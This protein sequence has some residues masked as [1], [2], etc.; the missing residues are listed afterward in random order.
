MH[1][2]FHQL[3]D[4]FE[5]N[6]CSNRV[7]EK[8]DLSSFSSLSEAELV[9][10]EISNLSN[11]GAIGPKYGKGGHRDTI[12]RIEILNPEILYQSLGRVPLED[13]VRSVMTNIRNTAQGWEANIIDHIEKLWSSR[14]KWQRLSPLDIDI[15][16]KIQRAAQAIKSDN[17]TYS[18][19][20]TFSARV[21]DDSKFMEKRENAVLAY[22]NYSSNDPIF[23]FH[24]F[25]SQRGADKITP[26]ILI[27][28]PFTHN[29]HSIGNMVDYCGIAVHELNSVTFPKTVKYV[30]T[31]E[32]L[33]SFHRH[34]CEINKA[35]DGIILYTNGQPSHA[36]KRFY[37][38]LTHL[39]PD[40]IPFYHWSDIDA[41]GL[42]ISNVLLGLN[43]KLLPHLMSA[44]ILDEYGTIGDREV[45]IGK[46]FK[47]TWLNPI[48][49][50]LSS[51]G[52][53]TVEQE[54]L[55]PLMPST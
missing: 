28:G 2:V 45:S 13:D 55:N 54:V 10:K 33:T 22:F 26:P 49:V 47:G 11:L 21:T 53:K 46:T 4:R 50:A 6:K 20:R 18:D 19:A 31:I 39:L 23:S 14:R 52:G 25:M 36:F 40:H 7:S 15:L 51:L 1:D 48:A 3:L 44:N 27:S 17:H 5:K 8:I 38:S 16:E 9:L 12:E 34:S 30:L 37:S 42:E 41:G 43:S 29:G 24:D 32:N 35:K